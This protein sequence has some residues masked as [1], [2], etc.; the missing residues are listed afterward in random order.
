MQLCVHISSY[1][2]DYE[3]T[4]FDKVAPV[5]IIQMR[6]LLTMQWNQ[7]TSFGEALTTKQHTKCHTNYTA[8]AFRTQSTHRRRVTH[9]CVSK[10]VEQC[11]DAPSPSSHYLNQWWRIVKWTLKNKIQWYL[12]QNT[13]TGRGTSAE[14]CGLDDVF[15]P[16]DLGS[17]PETMC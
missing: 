9:V 17:R 1:K 12:H 11:I 15:P 4:C 3:N 14:T 2:T 7:E 6:F 10:L 13:T 5:M 8:N 16:D